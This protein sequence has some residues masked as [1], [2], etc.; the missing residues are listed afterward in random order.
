MTGERS[1]RERI[2]VAAPWGV[3]RPRLLEGALSGGLIRPPDD[4]ITDP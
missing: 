4:D 2:L 3:L 1:P